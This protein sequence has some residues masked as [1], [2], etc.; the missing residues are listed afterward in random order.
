MVARRACLMPTDQ[1][2][3]AAPPGDAVRETLHRLVDA[4]TPEQASAL[5]HF[6]ALWTEPP[7]ERGAGGEAHT[8]E[9]VP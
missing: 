4:L 2:P 6:L 3:E 1:P 8:G 7:K 5:L 9:Q